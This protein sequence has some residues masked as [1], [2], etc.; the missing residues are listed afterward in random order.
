VPSGIHQYPFCPRFQACGKVI[1]VPI[2]ALLPDGFAVG[3]LTIA[4][5]IVANAKVRTEAGYPNAS[6]GSEHDGARIR[7]EALVVCP[8]RRI[9]RHSVVAPGKS[10]SNFGV[11]TRQTRA[12]HDCHTRIHVAGSMGQFGELGV[13][14]HAL[15][16][17][18]LGVNNSISNVNANAAHVPYK[19]QS[20]HVDGLGV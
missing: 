4:E 8:A 3:I 18:K 11:A 9:A 1:A 5:K 13:R 7:V 10:W 17:V 16:I 19:I 15:A 14:F 2:P 12:Q 20:G 6:A